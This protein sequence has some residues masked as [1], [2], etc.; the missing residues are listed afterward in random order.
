MTCT[1]CKSLNKVVIEYQGLWGSQIKEYPLEN[2]LRID[3]QEIRFGS[4]KCYRPV[5]VMRTSETRRI[6]PSYVNANSH[7]NVINSIN[8]FL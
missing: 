6:H 2:I 8:S 3:N 4:L 5:L 7:K 1:F